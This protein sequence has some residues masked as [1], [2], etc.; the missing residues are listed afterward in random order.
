MKTWILHAILKHPIY[1]S[2]FCQKLKVQINFNERMSKGMVWL[3]LLI[4]DTFLKIL[5]SHSGHFGM[6]LVAPLQLYTWQCRSEGRSV[7]RSV[8]RSVG[9]PCSISPQPMS[10]FHSNATTRSSLLPLSEFDPFCETAAS[11]DASLSL[12][13]TLR[14][15]LQIFS[16]RIAIRYKALMIPSKCTRRCGV[17]DSASNFWVK[18]LRFESAYFQIFLF[19][20][21]FIF[22]NYIL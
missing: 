21:C 2:N 4:F 20:I 18:G 12:V 5:L 13:Y 14:Y 1:L 6:F 17:M 3:L 7:C 15:H 10:P 16:P 8:C 11:S 9:T 19:I 22:E